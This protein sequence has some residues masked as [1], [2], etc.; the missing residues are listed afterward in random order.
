MK[1]TVTMSYVNMFAVLKTLENLC[2]LDEESKE[3]VS[4][5]PI[6]IG[7]SVKNG[8]KATLFFGGGKCRMEEGAHGRIKLFLSS[9]DHFNAMVD[10]TKNPLPYGGLLRLNFLLKDFTRLTEILTKYLKASAEDLK[11][12]TFFE[13]STTLMFHLVANALS[14]VGNYDSLGCCSK[15]SLPDGVISMEISDCVYAS[16]VMR[17]GCLTTLHEHAANPRSYMIFKNY[18][19]ARGLF[20]GSLD[21]M[22][23][24]ARGDLAMKGYIPQIDNLNRI[25]N[26][27]SVYLS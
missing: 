10:G 12:R 8:P 7:F 21:S 16:I 1:D 9:P 19:V 27:V 11:D 24:L 13:K 4:C 14:A 3:I 6:S 18:D 15:Q 17:D 2:E 20:S 22:S 26:R 23:C 5:D 25:L